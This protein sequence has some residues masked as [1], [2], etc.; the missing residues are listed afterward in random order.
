VTPPAGDVATA[1][2]NVTVSP[3][4][5]PNNYAIVIKASTPT[6]VV[7]QFFIT[8]SDCVRYS[9]IVVQVPSLTEFQVAVSPS[10]QSVVI[11]ED[12]SFTVQAASVGGFASTVQLSLFRVPT[13][14]IFSFNPTTLSPTE[15][16]P[17]TSTLTVS[18]TTGALAGDYNVDVIGMSQGI[19][20]IVTIK[21]TIVAIATQLT[22]TV[23][24]TGVKRGEAFT[25]RGTISPV[26]TGAP[27]NVIYTR[28]DGS[29]FTHTVQTA[30]DGTFSD[31]YTPQTVDLIGAWK[32]RAEFIANS[33]Y[34]GST[35]QTYG[36]QVVEK[37]FLEQYG[38]LWLADYALW[39]VLLIIAI[40]LIVAAS[41]VAVRRIPR[42][43]GRPV[44]LRAP[45]VVAT[46]SFPTPWHPMPPRPASPIK[47]CYNCGQ[48]LAIEARFCDN[49]RAPQAV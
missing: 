31:Q 19:T 17:V 49:C 25:V 38:L 32:V 28:P 48:T 35:T 29:E 36:F 11:N 34:S 4:L 27:I 40:V 41:I 22:L 47:L 8:T 3:D 15:N 14:L 6:C 2:L 37:S 1:V 39:I 42:A 46:P 12:V 24:S 43:P 9:F 5:A 30:S 10:T 23:P 7:S 33:V 18:P 21:L 20:K 13:G 16:N 26:L 44:S 45:V